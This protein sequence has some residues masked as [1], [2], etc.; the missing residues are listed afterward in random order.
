MPRRSSFHRY[1]SVPPKVPK[2]RNFCCD[3][4]KMGNIPN[5]PLVNLRAQNVAPIIGIVVV[6][7]S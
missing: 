6:D 7:A 1:L 3:D 2:P 5:L 4:T